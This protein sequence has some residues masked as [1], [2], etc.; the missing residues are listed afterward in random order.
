MFGFPDDDSARIAHPTCWRKRLQD[1]SPKSEIF[2][3]I[4]L[5]WDDQK[6][7]NDLQDFLRIDIG[8]WKNDEDI[9]LPRTTIFHNGEKGK[10]SYHG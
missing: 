3:L 1:S 9:R 7:I 5:F 6:R 4:N 2:N 10:D 8:R